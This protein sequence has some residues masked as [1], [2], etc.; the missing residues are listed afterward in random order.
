MECIDH[1]IFLVALTMLEITFYSDSHM[2]VRPSVDW[3]C[4]ACISLSKHVIRHEES[5]RSS[6]ALAFGCYESHPGTPP[7]FG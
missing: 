3:L 5:A 6:E 4:K 1:P 7:V 2:P